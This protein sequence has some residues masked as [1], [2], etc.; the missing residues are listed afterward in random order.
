[1]LFLKYLFKIFKTTMAKEKTSDVKN[2]SHD[3]KVKCT[4]G[5]KEAF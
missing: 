5:A 4:M 1:L 2:H 3:M